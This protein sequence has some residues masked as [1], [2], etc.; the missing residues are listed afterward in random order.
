VE[1]FSALVQ[2]VAVITPASSAVCALYAISGE[3]DI[4]ADSSLLLLTIPAG[5]LSGAPAVSR[6][7]ASTAEVRQ[8]GSTALE[9]LR[10]EKDFVLCLCAPGVASGSQ[11]RLVGP[12]AESLSV[13]VR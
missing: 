6:S 7:G 4:P 12:G 5:K 8:V 11:Q 13:G 1:R 9:A 3:A 2:R 10:L